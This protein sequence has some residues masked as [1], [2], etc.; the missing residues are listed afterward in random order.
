MSFGETSI[1]EV[2]I[3]EL[4]DVE[5]G[6]TPVLARPITLTLYQRTVVTVL[7]ADSHSLLLAQPTRAVVLS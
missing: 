5:V 6:E 3:G 7:A 2:A 4:V 1:G